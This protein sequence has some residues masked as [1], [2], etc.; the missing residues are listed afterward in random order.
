MVLESIYSLYSFL[1]SPIG[2]PDRLTETKKCSWDLILSVLTYN[3]LFITHFIVPA[4][5]QNTPYTYGG[6]V[7]LV[8]Y[9]YKHLK[10]QGPTIWGCFTVLC[11]YIWE[12]ITMAVSLGFGCWIYFLHHSWNDIT[13]NTKYGW[14]MFSEEMMPTLYEDT[15]L[16]TK[17][18]TEDFLRGGLPHIVP[19]LRAGSKRVAKDIVSGYVTVAKEIGPR[20][21]FDVVSGTT[22]HLAKGMILASCRVCKDIAI[23]G[24]KSVGQL[25]RHSYDLA[26]TQSR[27]LAIEG[28]KKVEKIRRNSWAYFSSVDAG[29][30]SVSSPPVGLTTTPRR[31]NSWANIF[32]NLDEVH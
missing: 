13:R 1:S 28:R 8:K 21:M 22:R 31:R 5:K 25:R 2:L 4:I 17:T 16:A 14:S 24:T 32:Q 23:E 27:N 3:W 11:L 29:D 30:E 12:F 9:S 20:I 6:F 10:Y 26:M 7:S 19:D 15:A 18:V